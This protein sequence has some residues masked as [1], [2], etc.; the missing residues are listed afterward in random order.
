M[1]KEDRQL[2]SNCLVSSP[3]NF[4]HR[5][6]TSHAKDCTQHSYTCH[7][8]STGYWNTWILRLPCPVQP[9]VPRHSETRQVC[10]AA[11]LG[12]AFQRGNCLFGPVNL[13]HRKAL[14]LWCGHW[15]RAL[16][17]WAQFPAL[18]GP[19]CL[20]HITSFLSQ[21]LTCDTSTNT[22]T[23]TS[24]HTPAVA[25]IQWCRATFYKVFFNCKKIRNWLQSLYFHP[26]CTVWSKRPLTST[27]SNTNC[28][29]VS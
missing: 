20:K 11:V 28:D 13:E 24:T 14:C 27:D 21:P 23:I 12:T 18:A 9:M 22:Q 29:H 10:G 19:P 16:H 2:S 15:G 1:S 3:G 17:T 5:K 25:W 26:R 6:H 8:S 4:L 7:S